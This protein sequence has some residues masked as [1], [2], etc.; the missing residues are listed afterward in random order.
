MTLSFLI[1][2]LSAL[3]KIECVGS[4]EGISVSEVTEISSRAAPNTVFVAIKGEK[5]NGEDY[6][7]EARKRGASVFVA[8][9]KV[10]ISQG[11]FLIVAESARV[12]LAAI[13]YILRGATLSEMKIIGV[14]GTKG[15][16]TTARMLSHILADAGVPHILI[17][18]LGCETVIG[19]REREKTDNTT[20]SAPYIHKALAEAYERGAKAAVI[21]ASSQALK[22]YRLFSIPFCAAVFTNLT[23][24]HIGKGE[25]ESF[26]EYFAAKRSLFTDYGVKLAIVNS[27]DPY[28]ARISHGVKRVVK[29][30]T[31]VLSD[32][33]IESPSVAGGVSF[34]LFGERYALGMKGVFNIENAALALATAKECFGI[35][36]KKMVPTLAAFGVE[37]RYEE[38][39][40]G[41]KRIIIDFAHNPDSFLAIMKSAA[42]ETEG[43][44]I[45]VFGSV[46]GRSRARRAAIAAVAEAFCDIS[47]ITSDNPDNEPPELIA[48]DM[49]RG[50]KDTSRAIVIT[51]RE[52][53]IRWALSTADEGD[54][55]LLLG[56]GHESYQLISGKKIPFSEREIIAS[57]GAV[58][59]SFPLKER[60]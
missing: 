19:K 54:T 33:R 39:R 14:T 30:G 32:Y 2:E 60:T 37:G 59:V 4:A 44:L 34:S 46:G 1:S 20:P 35:L 41:E 23:P 40:I 25:H 57:L 51:D 36:P 45:S 16:T 6:I 53:A 9:R 31:S 42:S 50:F 55:V 58:K 27:L 43:R 8:E 22:H 26:F 5:R 48:S 15:K 10:R 18:T 29:V 52:E 47:V 21:E 13:S 17:G 56:K 38:Y 7:N 28:S 3:C 11:E 49:L 12:A 24:D